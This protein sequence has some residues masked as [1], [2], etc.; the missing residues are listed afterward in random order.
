[1]LLENKKKNSVTK[2]Y[3][4]LV[5]KQQRENDYMANLSRQRDYEVDKINRTYQAK[6]DASLRR[7]QELAL[8]IEMA[9]RFVTDIDAETPATILKPKKREG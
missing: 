4:A 2:E 7:Q 9:K 6:I 5:A 3:S 1:M 8:Q